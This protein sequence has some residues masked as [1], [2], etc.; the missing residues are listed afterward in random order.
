M[1]HLARAGTKLDGTN[2]LVLG[3]ICRHYKIPVDVRTRRGKVKG[4][5]HFENQIWLTQVPSIG[6]DGRRRHLGRVA[7]SHAFFYPGADHRD[8]LRGE[9]AL[10]RKFAIPMRG[11]PWRHVA[12]LGYR[13]D[14]CALLADVLIGEQGERGGFS[15]TV[16]A[17]AVLQDDG[18]DVFRDG[19]WGC[20]LEGGGGKKAAKGKP[21]RGSRWW[22]YSYLYERKWRGKVPCT[23][24]NAV[25]SRNQ[26]HA[27]PPIK[28]RGSTNPATSPC[29]SSNREESF[30]PLFFNKFLHGHE[31]LHCGGTELPEPLE[32]LTRANYRDSLDGR[33]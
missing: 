7:L 30:S 32:R 31:A 27:N 1:N 12:G 28:S 24:C 3:Q 20:G 33:S 15:G 22:S 6:E 29:Y 18:R 5:R 19:D 21:W 2:P 17:R 26:S 13:R 8:L 11:V 23:N 16:A 4:H 10:I 9:A 14:Q 25:V